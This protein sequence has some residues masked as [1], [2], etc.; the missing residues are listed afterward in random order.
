[1]TPQKRE[2]DLKKISRFKGSTMLGNTPSYEV[3]NPYTHPVG[4]N[5]HGSF[6]V[7]CLCPF[8]PISKV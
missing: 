3:G 6:W 2:D 1:M 5:R 4:N 7:P 8:Y